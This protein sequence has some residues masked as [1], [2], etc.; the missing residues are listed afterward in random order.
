MSMFR[1]LL[2]TV[3]Y[4]ASAGALSW[5]L[6]GVFRSERARLGV[7]FDQRYNLSDWL[8]VVGAL[9]DST[10]PIMTATESRAASHR[11]VSRR[12]YTA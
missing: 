8:A 4:L 9:Y 3:T 1:I 12:R 2:G 10:T 11:I 6:G 5:W 7:A